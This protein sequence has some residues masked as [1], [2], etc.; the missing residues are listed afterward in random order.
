MTLIQP[1]QTQECIWVP[2]V[3]HDI[4]YKNIFNFCSI[5]TFTSL[6]CI[7]LF[8]CTYSFYSLSLSLSE[9]HKSEARISGLPPFISTLTEVFYWLTWPINKYSLGYRYDSP[10][11]RTLYTSFILSSVSHM[12]SWLILSV[13]IFLLKHHCMLFVLNT[14]ILGWHVLFVN[15][16]RYLLLSVAYAVKLF[17]YDT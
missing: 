7:Q 12:W 2:C 13:I 10:S 3:H 16:H 6:P 15:H 1:M 14:F 5:P 17:F 4:W 8:T 9:L 11:A